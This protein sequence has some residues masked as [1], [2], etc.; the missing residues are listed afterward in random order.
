MHAFI[1]RYVPYTHACIHLYMHACM[2]KREPCYS[3]AILTNHGKSLGKF[4]ARY[5]FTRGCTQSVHRVCT[6]LKDSREK[7]LHGG[8]KGDVGTLCP[9]AFP[10]PASCFSDV[11]E[12]WTCTG[13]MKL[14]GNG[15]IHTGVHTCGTRAG[16]ESGGDDCARRRLVHRLHAPS[17]RLSYRIQGCL[18][19][20][21]HDRA[22]RHAS[23]RIGASALAHACT[24]ST[25]MRINDPAMRKTRCGRTDSARHW[26]VS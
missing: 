21:P 17:R 6:T 13:A 5:S 18:W 2:A 7:R 12:H 11:N 10:S 25:R 9:S 4:R 16:G 3:V 20:Y 8:R 23:T 24:N 22:R 19:P 26:R 15:E 1:H 14:G